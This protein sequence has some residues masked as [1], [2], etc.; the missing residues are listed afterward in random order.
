MCF[1]P[2]IGFKLC[3]FCSLLDGLFVIFLCT[4][5]NLR[6]DF[7][8]HVKNALYSRCSRGVMAPRTELAVVHC[9]F[10]AWIY[11]FAKRQ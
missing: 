11:D 8:R 9:I 7:F 1:R 4:L 2:C 6:E 3:Q 10:R 5:W